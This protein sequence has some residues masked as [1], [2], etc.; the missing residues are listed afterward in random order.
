VV[1]LPFG[2]KE[3]VEVSLTIEG[4]ASEVIAALRVRR[5]SGA[6]RSAQIHTVT[7]RP[8]RRWYSDEYLPMIRDGDAEA[9]KEKLNSLVRQRLL[10]PETERHLDEVIAELEVQTRS[11]PL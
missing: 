6:K 3:D 8:D 11:K 5:S 7:L 10:T 1:N 2:M 9:A 4:G